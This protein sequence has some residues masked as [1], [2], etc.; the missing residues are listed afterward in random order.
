MR[1]E[2]NTARN[3]VLPSIPLY[4]LEQLISRAPA[5][6]PKVQMQPVFLSIVSKSHVRGTQYVVEGRKG[7]GR[8]AECDGACH[9]AANANRGGEVV[10]TQSGSVLAIQRQGR[11]GGCLLQVRVE[12]L[13]GRT[14]RLSRFDGTERRAAK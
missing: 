14:G 6:L 9:V 10:H 8:T 2:L 5:A 3:K 13:Y 11:G 12:L 1:K 4:P 7:G